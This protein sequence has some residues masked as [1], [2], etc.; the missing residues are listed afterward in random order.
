MITNVIASALAPVAS[1]LGRPAPR[2]RSTLRPLALDVGDMLSIVDGQGALL[3]ARSGSLW[4]TDE[5][6]PGDVVLSPGQSHRIARGG[7]TVVEA[8]RPARVVVEVPHGVRAPASITLSLFGA[9]GQRIAMQGTSLAGRWQIFVAAIARALNGTSTR[10]AWE[11]PVDVEPGLRRSSAR[12]A[13]DAEDFTPEA[14]RDR[15]QRHYPYPYY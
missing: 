3:H 4:I 14:V 9:A 10:F 1:P 2:S 12:R 5:R 6:A 13:H 8:H 7:T 11:D 15:L